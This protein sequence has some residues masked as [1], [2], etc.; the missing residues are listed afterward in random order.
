M[1]EGQTDVSDTQYGSGHGDVKS[2]IVG[3]ALSLLLTIIPF[4]LVMKHFLENRYLFIVLP[5]LALLQF[6]V[7]L[8]FFLH[9]NTSSKARWNLIVFI[10]TLVVVLILVIGSLWIMYNLNYNMVN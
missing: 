7:Q 8:V 5:I 2:Y 10:F 6:F 9:L 4:T 1:D 3:F